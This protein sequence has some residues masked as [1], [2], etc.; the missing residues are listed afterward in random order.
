[1]NGVPLKQCLLGIIGGVIG[2]AIGLFICKWLATQGF[3]AV[4]IPGGLAGLG[5][6]YGARHRS[7][8][9]GAVSG[10]LGLLAGLITQWKV[11]SNE[12]SFFKLVGE[13]KDYSMVTW[14]LLGL[15]AVLAFSFGT[16]RNSHTASPQVG[17]EVGDDAAK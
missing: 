15:G 16:G 3:Y 1:M 11:Y 4:A 6:G 7:F 14:F 12:P 8:V 17:N 2:G 5:F 9:F 10:V 13:L